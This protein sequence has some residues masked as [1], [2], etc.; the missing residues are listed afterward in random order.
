MSQAAQTL[1]TLDQLELPPIWSQEERNPVIQLRFRDAANN[2]EW[3]V[4][5]GSRQS[6]D[7]RFYGFQVQNFPIL[8][9]FRLSDLHLPAEFD[10]SLRGKRWSEIRLSA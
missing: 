1:N 5:E 6:D 9:H 4:I 3:Y 8:C 7:Y 10:I 2:T